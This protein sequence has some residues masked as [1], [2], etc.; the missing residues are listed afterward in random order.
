M[1]PSIHYERATAGGWLVL[2]LLAVLP[3]AGAWSQDALVPATLGR[4]TGGDGEWSCSSAAHAPTAIRIDA[5]AGPAG[6]PAA[7]L[8]FEYTTVKYNWNWATVS[9]GSVVPAG[10]AAVRVTYM[11]DMPQGF[12]GLNV[13]VREATKAGYWVP[14]GLPPSPGRFRTETLP[15]AMFTLPPWSRDEN[16]KLDVDCIR[17]VSIGVETG[18]AGT[19]RIVIADVVLVPEGW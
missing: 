13:M 8:E 1:W 4:G 3:G 6:T 15:F 2:L 12:P 19:G 14:K 16:G 18:A 10:F 7:V 11:T 9:V 17:A 5:A